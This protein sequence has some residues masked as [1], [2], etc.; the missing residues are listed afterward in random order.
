M[1]AWKDVMDRVDL[2]AVDVDVDVDGSVA[3]REASAADIQGQLQNRR[4]AAVVQADKS[5]RWRAELSHFSV[6]FVHSASGV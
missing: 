3:A 1:L 2:G 5:L 6:R 4:R